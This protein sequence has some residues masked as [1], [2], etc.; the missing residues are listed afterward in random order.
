VPF[1][2][3]VT[4]YPTPTIWATGVLGRSAI[5][6]S[7]QLSGSDGGGR[8]IVEKPYGKNLENAEKTNFFLMSKVEFLG[9]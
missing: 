7:R 3:R 9:V 6:F 1:F 5:A 2:D 4:V 8:K